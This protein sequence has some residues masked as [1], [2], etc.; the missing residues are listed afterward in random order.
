MPMP[1][2]YREHLMEVVSNLLGGKRI[3]SAYLVDDEEATMV[4]LSLEVE[5][6]INL[7]VG[8][9]ETERRDGE[10]EVVFEITHDDEGEN[11]EDR[12]LGLTVSVEPKERFG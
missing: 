8:W 2:I 10:R 3:Q 4:G 6:G 7:F 1:P 5:G 9:R 12:G 11:R